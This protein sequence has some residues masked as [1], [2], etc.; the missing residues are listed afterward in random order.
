MQILCQDGTTIQCRDFEVTGSGVLFFRETPG[1]EET[2]EENGDEKAERRASGFV[3]ITELQ[4]VLPDEMTGQGGHSAP[5]LPK[6]GPR[7]LPTRMEG[8]SNSRCRT[9]PALPRPR[10][11]P[12]R[13]PGPAVAERRHSLSP[14]RAVDTHRPLG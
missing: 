2:E 1:R 6:G 7:P 12:S 13:A 14:R 5:A 9:S 4:F 8:C 11:R 10:S 3:P